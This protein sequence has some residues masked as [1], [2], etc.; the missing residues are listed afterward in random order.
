MPLPD[1]DHSGDDHSGDDHSGADP[2]DDH[3]GRS[4]DDG[5]PQTDR[6]HSGTRP[7]N[8]R[9]TADPVKSNLRIRSCES[10]NARRTLL[11]MTSIR[12]NGNSSGPTTK[13]RSKYGDIS[14]AVDW[15]RP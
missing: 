5:D 2:G 1:A 12:G 11:G 4:T 7:D 3:S 10:Q 8:P 6:H 15:F 9:T 14:P 13:R